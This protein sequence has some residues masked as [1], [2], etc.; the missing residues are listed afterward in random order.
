MITGYC[1][2]RKRTKEYA[3]DA[4]V[5]FQD[6]LVGVCGVK[7]TD[8][9]LVCGLSATSQLGVLESGACVHGYIEKKVC[10]PEND[11]FIGAG[12]VDM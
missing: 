5:L 10:V 4:L 12:L 2:Q 8:T 1:T 7:M 6:I 9:T 11:V 3:H